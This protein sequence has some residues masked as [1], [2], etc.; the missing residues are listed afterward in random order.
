MSGEEYVFRLTAYNK[1]ALLPEVSRALETRNE[2]VSQAKFSRRVKNTDFI[3]D[4]EG[5]R[6]RSR[7]RSFIN[8]IIL[9]VVGAAAIIY[10]LTTLVGFYY[11]LLFAGAIAAFIGV[12]SLWAGMPGR[13]NPFDKSAAKLLDGKDKFLAEDDI[14]IVFDNHGMKATNKYIPYTE[15]YCGFETNHTF[16]LIFGPLVTLVQKRD[17]IEGDLDGFRALLKRVL[18]TFIKVR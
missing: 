9:I 1:A 15:F 13:K 2:L 6:Q 4:L 5:H 10:S 18:P 11:I 12:L 14:R 3:D 8:G 16:L 7:R 17:L